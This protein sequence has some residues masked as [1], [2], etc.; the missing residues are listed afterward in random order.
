MWSYSLN[1]LRI[2]MILFIKQDK[3]HVSRL[4]NIGKLSWVAFLN[5]V[6]R[7]RDLHK[8]IIECVKVCIITC[9]VAVPQVAWLI[10]C[11][12]HLKIESN[13]ACA[14]NAGYH[15]VTYCETYPWFLTSRFTSLKCHLTWKY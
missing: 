3:L 12:F 2:C 4:L 14:K 1:C 11:A 6:H 9:K 10:S 8:I 7:G 15:S 5:K 13:S